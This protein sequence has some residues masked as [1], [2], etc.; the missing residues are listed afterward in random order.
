MLN[1]V[2]EKTGIPAIIDTDVNAA[3]LGEGRW[4]A[5]QGFSNYIYL[6]IGT[7]I[8]GG[9]IV[10][11]RPYH[12]L[13]HPEMGHIY[14]IRDPKVDPFDGVCPFH[15]DCFEGL[16][17]GPALNARYSQPAETLPE[18]HPAWELESYYIATA[19]SDYI[20]TLSPERIILGG[21]VMQ[22]SQLFPMVRSKVQQ[23][24]NRYVQSPLIIDHID[25]YILPPGLGNS[26]GVL[27]AI[28][29]A[30]QAFQA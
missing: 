24:L 23:L 4:G 25:D 26:A 22:Q 5:T 8:G 28:A 15:G 6:T 1:S 29:L 9:L 2:Q 13:V 30:E 27:G 10:D 7:G 12:G 21:G 3:A 16:A 18:N 17:S 19:L 11:G 20:C 14:L